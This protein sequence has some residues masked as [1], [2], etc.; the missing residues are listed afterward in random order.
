MGLLDMLAVFRQGDKLAELAELVAERC[1]GP[2]L[3]RVE[4]LAPAMSAAE[5][6]G[7]IRARAAAV[8]HNEVGLVDDLRVSSSAARRQQ[9]TSLATDAVVRRVTAE[10]IT[11]AHQATRRRR[12]A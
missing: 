10:L 12:A 4:Q 6:L 2:V 11:R 7:Y 1:R 8:V 3:V 5:S 9:L